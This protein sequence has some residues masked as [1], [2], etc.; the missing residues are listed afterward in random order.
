MQVLRPSVEGPDFAKLVRH[1]TEVVSQLEAN[2]FDFNSIPEFFAKHAT[3][4]VVAKE[5][6]HVHDGKTLTRYGRLIMGGVGSHFQLMGP[7]PPNASLR[8]S[9]T[10]ILDE[11]NRKLKSKGLNDLREYRALGKAEEVEF[12]NYEIFYTLR[13]LAFWLILHQAGS[14]PSSL[15]VV[16][17]HM[18]AGNMVQSNMY[19]PRKPATNSKKPALMV[20]NGL[21]VRF[22]TDVMEWMDKPIFGGLAKDTIHVE[23][24]LTTRKTDVSHPYLPLAR[25]GKVEIAERN[26]FYRR[27][28]GVTPKDGLRGPGVEAENAEDRY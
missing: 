28:V 2:R 23:T 19:A 5:I 7:I 22:K 8:I 12:Y 24:L 17:R 6:V 20:A 3:A 13:D 21:T 1:T 11:V 27:F 10:A 26:Y 4:D 14:F 18:A 15:E 25:E 9:S 16:V